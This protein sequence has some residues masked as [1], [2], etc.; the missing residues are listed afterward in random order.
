VSISG[1]EFGDRV[2]ASLADLRTRYSAQRPKSRAAHDRAEKRIP[3]GLSR[4]VLA[5]NPFPIRAERATGAEIID[6][7]GHSY[8]DLCGD[9]TAGLLGHAP[10][11]V[12]AAIEGVLQRG[13]SY[14]ASPEDEIVV[15]E[16]LCRHF[17]SMGKVRLVN[18]GTEA[19]LL[20][21]ALANAYTGRAQVVA[22]RGG[23][24][25]SI[26]SFSTGIPGPL[27]VPHKVR[28]ADFNVSGG[29]LA[30]LLSTREVSC[31]IIEPM[32]GAGGCVV[33]DHSFLKWLMK[34]CDQSGTLLIFDEVMTSRLAPGGMQTL[35]G[36]RPDLTTVGK[37][38]ASGLS[39]GAVGG[40]DDV[41]RLL[42]QDEHPIVRHSGTFNNNVFSMAAARAV[43]ESELDVS[44][45]A[46][47]NERGNR[48]RKTIDQELHCRGVPLK[49]SG[50]GSMMHF[51]AEDPRLMEWLF[52]AL[53]KRGIYIGPTGMI[54][55]SL[56]LTDAMFVRA[57]VGVQECL[58]E[59]GDFTKGT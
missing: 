8:V 40:R 31:V 9:Y 41:L 43:L 28:L 10:E 45:I 38:L 2:E 32:Q 35:V 23:F 20:A 34:E 33:G 21:L 17:P 26:L 57:A 19:N 55:L 48:L 27:N 58:R 12:A 44:S 11:A 22:F 7:D 4:A 15:G 46:R 42:N 54:A 24:H 1:N 3:G 25:G 16:L 5:V 30:D 59:L 52:H 39:F 29:H 18:S 6:I 14:G 51:T 13:W 36:V 47:L 56:V 50:Y 37:Y 49:V 53:L